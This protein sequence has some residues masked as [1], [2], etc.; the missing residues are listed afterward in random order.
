M[1]ISVFKIFSIKITFFIITHSSVIN[2]PREKS[3]IPFSATLY[4]GDISNQCIHWSRCELSGVGGVSIPRDVFCSTG[5]ILV[6]T[7]VY[8]N[9]KFSDGARVFAARGK[10]LCCRPHSCNQISNW[11]SYGYNDGISVDCEQYAKLGV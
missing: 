10:R 2:I 1:Y 9:S 6:C 8:R 3:E 7:H 5:C 4:S 11:Y